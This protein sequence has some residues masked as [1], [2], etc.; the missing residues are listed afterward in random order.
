MLFSVGLLIAVSRRNA[1]A[2]QQATGRGQRLEIYGEISGCP[3]LERSWV[4]LNK[5]MSKSQ[6][7]QNW[8]HD[9]S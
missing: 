9:D 7:W 2:Q 5:N 3:E 4:G 8:I 1:W 6:V